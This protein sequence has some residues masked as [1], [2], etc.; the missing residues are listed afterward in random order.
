L[1]NVD[2]FYGRLEY[3]MDIC[4]VSG[5]LGTFCAHLVHFSGFGTM[6]KEKSG[7]P[8]RCDAAM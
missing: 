2:I 3:F 7:K 8:G 1:E 5:P 4:D 6:Y